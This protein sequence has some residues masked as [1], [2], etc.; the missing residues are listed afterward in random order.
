MSLF[1]ASAEDNGEFVPSQ[2]YVDVRIANSYEDVCADRL[3]AAVII[4]GLS[5]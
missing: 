3:C 1:D 5:T 2:R 4:S